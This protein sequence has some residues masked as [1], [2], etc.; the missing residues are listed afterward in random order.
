MTISAHL[1]IREAL[2]TDLERRP[3]PVTSAIT[4]SPAEEEAESR[5]AA[6]A[7]AYRWL[8]DGKQAISD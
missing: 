5:A 3:F 8:E 6:P 4:I 1:D 2:V 7:A